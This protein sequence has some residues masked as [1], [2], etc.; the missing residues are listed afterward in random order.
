MNLSHVKV[1]ES[2]R[3]WWLFRG[4]GKR[5]THQN[6]CHHLPTVDFASLQYRDRACWV[7]ADQ[8]F[9]THIVLTGCCHRGFGGL[10]YIQTSQRTLK[11]FASRKSDLDLPR[12]VKLT[13]RHTSLHHQFSLRVT[14]T[15]TT[16]LTLNKRASSTVIYCIIKSLTPVLFNIIYSIPLSAIVILFIL[17]T[18]VSVIQ[19]YVFNVLTTIYFKMTL[20]IF[21][22][23]QYKRKYSSFLFSVSKQIYEVFTNNSLNYLKLFVDSN[24]CYCS[25]N[26]VLFSS[27][28]NDVGSSPYY[29]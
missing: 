29:F 26:K 8:H 21:S 19:A 20:L 25:R 4:G 3:Q 14:C 1:E 13:K 23:L 9:T 7:C 24:L 27:S 11:I 17:E 6:P 15:S 28:Q 16:R 5:G 10:Y 18:A 12:D 2:K 22:H